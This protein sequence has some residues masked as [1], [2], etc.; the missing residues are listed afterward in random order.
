MVYCPTSDS[1]CYNRFE[2][3]PSSMYFCLLNL[4]GEFPLI[5]EHS[6]AGKVVASF[7]AIVAV[8][9]FAIPTGIIGSEFQAMIDER[10][11]E[12]KLVSSSSS[13]SSNERR[14]PIFLRS[15]AFQTLT[16][17]LV[18]VSTVSFFLSTCIRF[19]EKS[20]VIF[21]LNLF[22][23]SCV[24]VFAVEYVFDVFECDVRV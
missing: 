18:S 7:V 6:N 16:L 23:M 9:V 10:R 4:F 19:Q 17:I 24:F 3:I 22:E 8:A 15:S 1:S 20:N 13:S 5:G 12:R 21:V 2:S 14:S 11:R